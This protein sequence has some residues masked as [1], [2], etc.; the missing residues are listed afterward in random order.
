MMNSASGSASSQHVREH[1]LDD[2][3]A[4]WHLEGWNGNSGCRFRV[5]QSK[6]MKTWCPN[7]SGGRDAE[8]IE[9][10]SRSAR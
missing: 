3:A 6:E 7:Q 8:M 1:P 10:D 4:D 9:G 5:A 2:V